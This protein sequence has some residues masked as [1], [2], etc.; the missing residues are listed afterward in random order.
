[1]SVSLQGKV[2]LITGGSSGI[3]AAAAV[4]CAEAGMHVTLT[5]RRLDKLEAVARRCVEAGGGATQALPVV[6]DVDDD[7]SVRAA[8]A[9]SWGRFGRLDA[10]FA[11]A[12]VGLAKPVL[13]TTLD[14]HRA[15]FD[16]NVLGAVR[17][18]WPAAE[19][20]TRTPDGL[21]HIVINSS[22]L[23]DVGLPGSG[24]Y[25][26]TKAAQK[27]LAQALRA[28]VADR[29]MFVTSV[30]PVTTRTDFF[31]TALEQAGRPSQGVT[32]PHLKYA[33]D[34]MS[35]ARK[36]VRAIR[37]RKP[38]VW[39]SA[40]VRLAMALMTAF[41]ALSAWAMRR[42]YRRDRSALGE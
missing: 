19:D 14:E 4:A 15:I 18:L 3:G 27:S 16:T 7:A 38:E 12:G 10:V 11:N 37:R 31:D 28:E 9:A 5:A 2:I 26:A 40:G 6:A 25:S 24:A 41:P 8:F 42:Q 33:Q 34:P 23:S 32:N 13:D 29:G 1:M 21:R 39:G 22:C 30:H 17:T 35:I 20:L 36:V